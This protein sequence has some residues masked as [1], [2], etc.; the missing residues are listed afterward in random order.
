LI[1]NYG[2]DKGGLMQDFDASLEVAV[3]DFCKRIAGSAHLTAVG[4][5]D[6]S[7]D[8]SDANQMREALVVIKNFQ[9]KIMSYFNNFNN[10]TIYFLAV[11]QRIFESDVRR[12]LLGE[13]FA[14]KLVFPYTALLGKEY[15]VGKEFALK[16][17]LVLEL[18]ENLALNYPELIYHMKIKPQ[19]FLYEVMFNRLR[20]FPLLSH[21]YSGYLKDVRQQNE[22]EAASIYETVLQQL[23]IES[24]LKISDGY[25]T[26]SK[27]F[28]VKVQKS[29]GSLRNITKNAQR[30]IF[31][32]FF[33]S[34]PQL[35]NR[36]SQ[37]AT[38]F[39]RTQRVNWRGLLQEPYFVD[40]NAFLFVPTSGGLVS[41]ADKM[42]IREYVEK[43]FF[44]EG[45]VKCDIKSLGGVLNDV[46]LISAPV[47]GVEQR[48]LVK[49]FKEWSGFKW[50]PLNVWSRG[51]RSFAV[52]AQ[53][54]LAKECATS[55]FL[56]EHGFKVPKIYQISNSE[57]LVFMEFVE[58]EDLSMAI[59]RFAAAK[60]IGEA[61]DELKQVCLAGELMAKVH[62]TNMSLGDSKP[63]NMI[64]VADGS[65]YLLDFEQAALG[66]DKVWDIAEF[67][68]YSGHFLSPLNSTGKSEVLT[69]AFI[70]GYLQGGG[71]V[72]DI[73]KVG[74]SKYRRVFSIFTM[75]KII[76]QIA[77]V[78]EKAEK[79][80]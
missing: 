37:N 16:R 42:N 45:P 43:L 35:L 48:V 73:K 78:C 77:L 36:F 40:P 25:V 44:K 3:L 22:S 19:Y 38:V 1:H 53:S 72:D 2:G 79:K 76:T 60:T 49:R 29:K 52:S 62:A 74:D 4:L 54:R 26:V 41:L 23:S 71:N 64:S 14:G 56:L 68:Y 75:P 51:A 10:N 39:L 50:F 55:E 13:A 15:L 70:D 30:R 9:P 21:E 5:V 63:E 6:K 80:S 34:F 32:S 59:K 47:K 24:I 28:I 8:L 57:R 33:Q 31:Y 17:R 18:L 61:D 20:V 27:E 58:G 11:D 46:Y 12:G 67:L 65:I 66:G 7:A 69:Q